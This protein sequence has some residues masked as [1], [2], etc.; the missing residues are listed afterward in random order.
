MTSG[1]AKGPATRTR[2][3][4]LLQELESQHQPS[5]QREHHTEALLQEASR[6]VLSDATHQCLP[7]TLD[8]GFELAIR[9]ND[10]SDGAAVWLYSRPGSYSCGLPS[11]LR[12]IPLL[13][14][15]STLLIELLPPP[16]Q[17][18]REGP[19]SRTARATT[20]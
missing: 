14:V 17:T 3:G 18:L 9:H 7:V 16:G 19:L 4:Y 8:V 20:G 2:V 12:S 6:E 13:F 15:G 1:A 10:R 11:Q 5:D